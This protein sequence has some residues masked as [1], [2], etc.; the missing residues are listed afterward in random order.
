MDLCINQAAVLPEHP[1]TFEKNGYLVLRGVLATTELY[2]YALSIKAKGKLDDEQV[3]GTP[4]FY[5]DPVFNNVHAALTATIEAATGCQ[6]YQ[7]YTYF[8]IYK[9]GDVLR[10]HTD[11]DAC[12][13]S[14][15]LHIG[16]SDNWSIFLLDRD[17]NPVEVQLN[18]G[19]MLLYRGAELFHWRARYQGVGDYAQVFLHFVN[20][21]GEFTNH[22]KDGQRLLNMG[23]K[24]IMAKKDASS[25]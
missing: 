22:R 9:Q 6:L 15:T 23:I 18:A 16:S 14:G 11:R 1:A 21:N 12:E 7:T 20:R 17:E 10:C 8:R 13:I 4:S 25:T 24:A 19:D 5:G 3:L 2:D